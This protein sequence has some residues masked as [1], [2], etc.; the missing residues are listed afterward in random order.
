MEKRASDMASRGRRL[1]SAWKRLEER[2]GT[3]V[4]LEDLGAR[5]ADAEGRERGYTP[6]IV[7][8]WMLGTAEPGTLAIWTA[9]GQVLGVDPA[10]LAFGVASD[11]DLPPVPRLPQ[12]RRRPR[13][14]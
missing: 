4:T 2:E 6:A 9:L 13:G 11:D 1:F 5:I 8:R 7:S 12:P 3:R 14:D 10:Y